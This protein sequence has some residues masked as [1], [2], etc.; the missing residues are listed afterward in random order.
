MIADIARQV[1]DQQDDAEWRWS[2]TDPATGELLHN[3]ITRRR[4]TAALRRSIE[5]RDSTCIFPGCRMPAVDCDID[6]TTRWADGGPT[7]RRNQAPLCRHD[8]PTKD[9]LGW[10]YRRL[11]NGDYQWTTK[12]G[13]IYTTRARS[14]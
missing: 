9:R 4:P 10:K 13:H 11:P 2:I 8:H 7:T 3:A 14:P 12:L 6:H 5:A 1:A